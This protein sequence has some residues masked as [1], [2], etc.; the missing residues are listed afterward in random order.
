MTRPESRFRVADVTPVQ[1]REL[2]AETGGQPR[3]ASE[4]GVLKAFQECLTHILQHIN[5]FPEA[6]GYSE[7]KIKLAAH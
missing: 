7:I 6:Q 2:G 3:G 4:I 5:T 1:T